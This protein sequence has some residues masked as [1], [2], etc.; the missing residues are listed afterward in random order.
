MK[1]TKG[2]IL[3]A[4]VDIRVRRASIDE[5]NPCPWRDAV[6]ESL[7]AGD[8]MVAVRRS[9]AD[10]R[11]VLALTRFGYVWVYIHELIE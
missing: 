7:G 1:V 3:F 8:A 4:D 2:S 6:I 10:R 11:D 5:M 9:V